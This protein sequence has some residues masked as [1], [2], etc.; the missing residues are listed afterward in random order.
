M[1]FPGTLA[2]ST[3]PLH[4]ERHRK[5]S[6]FVN[7]WFFSL[8]KIIS[9]VGTLRCVSLKLTVFSYSRFQ[10]TGDVVMDSNPVFKETDF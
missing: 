5:P 6:L 2:G 3:T 4:I 9:L 1:H 7:L 10:T 8:P